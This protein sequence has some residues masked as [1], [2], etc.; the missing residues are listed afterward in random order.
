[1]NE[2]QAEIFSFEFKMKIRNVNCS[3]MIYENCK[4]ILHLK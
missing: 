3:F 4:D 2:F 1:M